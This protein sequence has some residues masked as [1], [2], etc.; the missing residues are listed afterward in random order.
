MARAEQRVEIAVGERRGR[1]DEHV[2]APRQPAVDRAGGA[3][4]GAAREQDLAHVADLVGQPRARAQAGQRKRGECRHVG[5]EGVDR[6]RVA[7]G[8]ADAPRGGGE[9]RGAAH[10][11]PVLDAPEPFQLRPGTG[12]GNVVAL[13]AEDARSH[14]GRAQ[15][16]DALAVARLRQVR[17]QEDDVHVAASG[18]RSYRACARVRPGA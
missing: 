11:A 6:V 18:G 13:E 9:R 7:R 1:H 5:A 15:A 16:G 2:R 8:A 14:A 17:E 4:A 3:A 12:P 10:V